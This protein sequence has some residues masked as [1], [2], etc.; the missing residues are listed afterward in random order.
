MRA[1]AGSRF[2]LGMMRFNGRR[3]KPAGSQVLEVASPLRGRLMFSVALWGWCYIRPAPRRKMRGG[4]EWYPIP[5]TRLP[6]ARDRY[7]GPPRPLLGHGLRYLDLV[8]V[9]SI[10]EG[11]EH[12]PLLG[13]QP[14]RESPRRGM[15]SGG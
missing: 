8:R 5:E 1:S 11:M 13:G 2:G 14:N 3:G 12:D 9:P 4:K 10:V 15:W 6:S 7:R